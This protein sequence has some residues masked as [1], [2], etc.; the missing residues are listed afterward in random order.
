MVAREPGGNPGLT[1]SGE[2]DGSGTRHWSCLREGAAAPDDAE[3]EDLLV[4]LRAPCNGSTNESRET[5]SASEGFRGATP[6]RSR[7]SRSSRAGG[8]TTPTRRPPI[9]LRRR[10][11][12]A[13]QRAPVRIAGR[14]AYRPRGGGPARQRRG[15]ALLWW[16]GNTIVV[17]VGVSVLSFVLTHLTPGDLAE[18][19]LTSQGIPATQEMLEAMRHQLGLDRPLWEQYVDWLRRMATGDLGTSLSMGTDIASDLQR[20]LPL[21]LALTVVSLL[22][23]WVIAVPIGLAAAAL[24]G[25]RLDITTRTLSYLSSALP[26]F[27]TGLLV[28]HLFGLDLRWFPISATHDARG[29]VMPVLTLVVSMA[30]WYVRQVRSIALEEL[31]KPYVTGLRIRGLSDV[32]I[33]AHVFR[34]V[35]APLCILAGGSFGAMLAGSAVVEAIFNWQGLGHYALDA[36]SAKDYPV[37]QTYVVWCATAFLVANAVA[38]LLA[39]A[40]DPRLVDGYGSRRARPRRVPRSTATAGAPPLHIRHADLSRLA[41]TPRVVPTTDGARR[42]LRLP[43]VP[44]WRALLSG[45]VLVAAAGVFAR[46]LTPFDPY[47]A[48]ISAALRAPSATHP[49]G[50]D[51]L[52]RDVLSRVL[53]GIRP[54]LSLALTV[55]T[56]SLAIGAVVGVLSAL[57]GGKVDA[58]LQRIT[59]VFQAFPEFILALAF[60]AMLGPGFASAVVAL[61]AVYWTRTARYSRV[62]TM[63]VKQAPFIQVARMNAAPPA[64]IFAAHLVPNIGSP[65]LVIA[66][67]DL[68]SVILNLATLSFVGLGLPQ[69]TSEWGTMISEGRVF[70]QAAPWLVIGPGAALFV[71]TL[72]VN[73]FADTSQELLAVSRRFQ[74]TEKGNSANDNTSHCGQPAH[75]GLAADR[76]Q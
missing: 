24:Q 75:R 40:L 7:S 21:T 72:M 38:D 18:N 58:L 42:S 5:D 14:S 39:F 68:G 60:A 62:L 26:G 6:E 65:L 66:A 76:L 13:D 45:L 70:L 48:D 4:T 20:R 8:T 56:C 34:N 1:R 63:Q 23:T 52:G 12:R 28:L 71:L 49:L 44:T 53:D 2:A 47:Q 54:T 69:P 43:P 36:I 10:A 59:A 51:P 30:G 50:T 27:V 41:K 15:V 57:A 19:M 35:A 31:D 25:G 46:H 16:V 33:S 64:R 9:G 11:P 61:T 32:R 74:S 3:S 17:L 55:V 67:A 22:V 73:L 29:L 37:I